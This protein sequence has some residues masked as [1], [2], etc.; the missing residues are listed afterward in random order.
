MRPRRLGGASGL[1]LNFTVRSPQVQ[2][3]LSKLRWPQALW[4][5]FLLNAGLI[6]VAWAGCLAVGIG[7]ATLGK[8]AFGCNITEGGDGG[9]PILGG[10][11]GLALLGAFG[12]PLFILAILVCLLGAGIAF[13]FRR[14]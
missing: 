2:Q 8:R 4:A 5:R 9:C 13:A 10:I 12:A 1:P 7:A 14:R 6:F 11:S 3:F